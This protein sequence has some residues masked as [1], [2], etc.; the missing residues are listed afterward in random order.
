MEKNWCGRWW[1]LCLTWE[2][3]QRRPWRLSL[4]YLKYRFILSTKLWKGLD[5]GNKVLSCVNHLTFFNHTARFV[6]G[7]W[8][9]L[10]SLRHLTIGNLLPS[11]E[12]R[13]WTVMLDRKTLWAVALIVHSRSGIVLSKVVL[14][15]GYF[16]S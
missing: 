4:L 10:I 14:R 15:F 16:C 12:L 8:S 2:S 13:D 5:L 11:V 6:N 9:I 7:L 3:M 1:T